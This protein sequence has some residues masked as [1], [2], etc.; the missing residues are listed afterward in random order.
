MIVDTDS[1]C[2]LRIQRPI[3]TS[4]L[5]AQLV[6]KIHHQRG[7]S[8]VKLLRYQQRFQTPLL[9]RIVNRWNTAEQKWQLNEGDI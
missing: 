7:V 2:L 9:P 5:T 1:G 8:D 6:R 4:T 3:H